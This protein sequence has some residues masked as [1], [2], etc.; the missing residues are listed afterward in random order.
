MCEDIFFFDLDLSSPLLLVILELEGTVRTDD[1]VV[2]ILVDVFEVKHLSV[3]QV[4]QSVPC[5]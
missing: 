3:F 1:R 4:F 5:H 2:I